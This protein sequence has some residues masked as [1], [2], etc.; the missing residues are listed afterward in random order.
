MAI[1]PLVE[2][3]A[4][5]VEQIQDRGINFL[6][7]FDV[8]DFVLKDG[9]FIELIGDAAVIFWIEKTLKT[10]FEKPA[11]YQ[12]TGYGT[13]LKSL[14]GSVMPKEIAKSILETSIKTALL[15]H[16][17]IES[18]RNFTFEQINESVDVSFE[19]KLN[20]I[21]RELDGDGGSEYGYTR[22]SSLEQIKD[23][24][25]IKLLTSNLL[26]FKTDLGGQIYINS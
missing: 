7:D 13:K 26:L 1:F 8:N 25:G 24:I 10:Q 18:I 21:A 17:R 20:P 19:V 9:K 22:I 6:F 11:V 16:E 23:F 12:N 5:V 2:T 15:T 4:E 14:K 3:E